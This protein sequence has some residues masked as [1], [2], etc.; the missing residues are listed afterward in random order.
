MFVHT[1]GAVLYHSC[2]GFMSSCGYEIPVRF[3]WR[4]S[5]RVLIGLLVAH[6]HS[7]CWCMTSHLSTDIWIEVYLGCR[8]A[9]PG[10]RDALRYVVRMQMCCNDVECL[11][12]RCNGYFRVAFRWVNL[13]VMLSFYLLCVD[14]PCFVS[15]KMHVNFLFGCRTIGWIVSSFRM[16]VLLSVIDVRCFLCL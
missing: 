1:V 4:Y 8:T 11:F 15:I 3:E 9:A 14:E 10:W 6:T 7:L 13:N 12:L 2:W 16:D 5:K